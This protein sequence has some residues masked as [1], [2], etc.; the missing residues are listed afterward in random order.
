M[1]ET[2]N[3]NP[4]VSKPANH[5]IVSKTVSSISSAKSCDIVTPSSMSQRELARS[6]SDCT[7]Y[8]TCGNN[9]NGSTFSSDVLPE[10]KHETPKNKETNCTLSKRSKKKPELHRPVVMKKERE[11]PREPVIVTEEISV[12]WDARKLR[13]QRQKSKNKTDSAETGR[14]RK[15]TKSKKDTT[16]TGHCCLQKEDSNGSS[17]TDDQ[18][19]LDV[20]NNGFTM[21]E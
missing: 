11:E 15:K 13:V 20:K 9:L 10:D 8:T 7:T 4:K 2:K 21:I 5:P 6:L 18:E 1:G 14:N 16:S 12:P 19:P 3:N 17:N